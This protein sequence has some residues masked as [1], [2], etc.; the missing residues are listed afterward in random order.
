MKTKDNSNSLVG[1]VIVKST[2]V[3]RSRLSLAVTHD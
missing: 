3:A 1:S 2:T